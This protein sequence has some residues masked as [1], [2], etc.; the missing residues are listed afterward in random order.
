M[1]EKLSKLFEVKI[2]D[3]PKQVQLQVPKLKKVESTSTPPT[4]QL[5]KLKKI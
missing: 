1:K 5:P 3:F 4:I 2:P